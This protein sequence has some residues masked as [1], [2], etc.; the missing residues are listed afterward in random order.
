MPESPTTP[1][2]QENQI[3]LLRKQL[4]ELKNA[5]LEVQE[6]NQQRRMELE[7]Q[8]Q[9]TQKLTMK[10]KS[11]ENLTKQLEEELQL[12]REGGTDK[13]ATMETLQDS[14]LEMIE[15]ELNQVELNVMS[16]GDLSRLLVI[17]KDQISR[18]NKERDRRDAYLQRKLERLEGNE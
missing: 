1:E 11:Q 7:T 8:R 6:Q 9:I 2:Q 3:H 15:Q 12:E 10:I 4:K 13:L 17:L 16:T 18:I 5:T 14:Y